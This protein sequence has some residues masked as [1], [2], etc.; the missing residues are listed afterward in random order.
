ML[1]NVE[2]VEEVFEQTSKKYLNV[3]TEVAAFRSK[4]RQ[5]TTSWLEKVS[6]VS[7]HQAVDAIDRLEQRAIETNEKY[8]QKLG[9]LT[10]SNLLGNL[11]QVVK[12]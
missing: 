4:R 6:P 8:L 5:M 2:K 10:R 12:K 3:L 9:T 7:I 11:A 1:Q